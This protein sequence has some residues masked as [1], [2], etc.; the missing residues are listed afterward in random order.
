MKVKDILVKL[1]GVVCL[2]GMVLN[3][4][5]N[6]K[7]LYPHLG[8]NNVMVNW[9]AV[10]SNW[11]YNPGMPHNDVLLYTFLSQRGCII[12]PDS[13]YRGYVDAFGKVIIYDEGCEGLVKSEDIDIE[14]YREIGYMCIT[15]H[16]TLFD[17]EVLKR[18]TKEDSP[19]LY[20]DTEGMLNC[21]SFVLFHDEHGN[22]YLKAGR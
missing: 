19:R 21:E 10:D 1:I 2:V 11:W 15:A 17:S 7:M 22:I 18:I 4:R 16:E 9:T 13:W 6:I 8:A 3:L 14:S 20:I 12:N 5:Y